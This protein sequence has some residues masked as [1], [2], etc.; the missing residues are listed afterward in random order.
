MFELI[1]GAL[2][3]SKVWKPLPY[4][5]YA[6]SLPEI[7]NLGVAPADGPLMFTLFCMCVPTNAPPGPPGIELLPD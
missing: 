1:V 7:Y 2:V 6:P 4:S 5:E 3:V